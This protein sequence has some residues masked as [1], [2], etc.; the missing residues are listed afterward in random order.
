MID[1]QIILIACT[2]LGHDSCK[3]VDLMVDPTI[4]HTPYH[5]QFAGMVEAEK[6]IKAHPGYYPKRWT[7]QRLTKET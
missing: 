6:W 5:C 4:P 3:T 2:I 1:L 7:C